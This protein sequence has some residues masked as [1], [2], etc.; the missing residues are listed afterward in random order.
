MKRY[1]ALVILTVI[2]LLIMCSCHKRGPYPAPIHQ[3]S[4]N[5]VKIDIVDGRNEPAMYDSETY[6]D[7]VIYSLKPE[8]FTP[9]IDGLKTI[10]F[11]A[12]LWEPDRALGFFVIWIY[13]ADGNADVIGTICTRYFDPDMNYLD[14]GVDNPDEETLYALVEQYVDPELLPRDWN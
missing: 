7:Y 9:F 4:E 1:Y 10:E 2:L 3:S 12:P 11:Y 6:Q 8:E 13:Y 14:Y 5:I